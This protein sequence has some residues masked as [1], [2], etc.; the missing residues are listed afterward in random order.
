[1]N[2]LR[3]IAGFLFNVIMMIYYVPHMCHD[4]GMICVK[5]ECWPWEMTDFEIV[6]EIE[7]MDK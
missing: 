3:F 5:K 2:I 7:R 1:M 6:E 4:V